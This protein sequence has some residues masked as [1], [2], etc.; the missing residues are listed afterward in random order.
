M[1]ATTSTI[2]PRGI[3]YA[4]RGES[5]LRGRVEKMASEVL[6]L[7]VEFADKLG[8]GETLTSA[9]TIAWSP[10]GPS[11][12]DPAIEGTRVKFRTSGGTDGVSY[13][14][15]LPSV[16]TSGGNVIGGQGWLDI[17]G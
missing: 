11:G 9:G 3:Y 14:F 7:A 2:S 13:Q 1:S 17:V 4:R 12:E 6:T 8:D 5:E 10:A 16:R 15:T